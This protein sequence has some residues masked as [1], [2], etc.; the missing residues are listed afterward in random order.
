[1]VI[2]VFRIKGK[3]T[4]VSPEDLRRFEELAHQLVECRG[5][6]D[7]GGGEPSPECVEGDVHKDDEQIVSR[8]TQAE[9]QEIIGHLHPSLSGD[10][11]FDSLFTPEELCTLDCI[12]Y[13]S[14]G[15]LSPVQVPSSI[16][17]HG[18]LSPP[19]S[20]PSS[21]Y[22]APPPGHL[23]PPPGHLAPPSGLL[24]PP[25]SHLAPPPCVAPQLKCDDDSDDHFWTDAADL[26]DGRSSEAAC[27]VREKVKPKMEPL[28]L[29][30]PV[31]V[32]L[33]DC[34]NIPIWSSSSQ[35]QHCSQDDIAQKRH[36][37]LQK[38]AARKCKQKVA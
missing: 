7:L 17:S 6:L 13:S 4:S 2:F 30:S 29:C 10:D 16:L 31:A 33:T 27:D 24:A 38:L 22:V 8:V 15:R 23:A 25:L 12:T 11:D 1:M 21:Y 3:G 37:A 35:P 20:A 14:A 26:L 19:S 34:S 36:K 28:H 9:Q 5:P 18:I 32:V